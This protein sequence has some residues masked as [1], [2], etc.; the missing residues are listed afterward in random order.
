V[1][2]FK[3]D[4]YISGI[5]MCSF[6]YHIIIPDAPPPDTY[7]NG[8][9]YSFDASEHVIFNPGDSILCA[10]SRNTKQYLS[11]LIKPEL[12]NRIA[13]EMDLSGDV[14]FCHRQRPVSHELLY[15]IKRFETESKRPDSFLLMLDCIGVQISAL[16][17]RESKSNLK[18]NPFP[19]AY[20][21]S[22]IDNAI[23]YMNEYY[24]ANITIDDICEEI[25]ISPFHFI[26]AFRKQ[27]GLTPHRYLLNL[28]IEK[29]A[30]MLQGRN[31]SIAETA[32]M[33]G[34]V[35][36]SRFSKAFKQMTGRSPK[37]YR[38]HYFQMRY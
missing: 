7:I 26:R 16:I 3:P 4:V 27:T 14:R 38:K 15:A 24:N 6:D 21:K 34:F 29:A 20:G 37:D 35:N 17:L 13:G 33:C 11:L 12:L 22:Y 19:P 5:E 1:A 2:V 31:F 32:R 28:R 36:L 25:N 8:K 30:E 23:S 18:K 9:L 10:E